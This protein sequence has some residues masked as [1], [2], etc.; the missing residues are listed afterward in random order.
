MTCKSAIAEIGLLPELPKGC[1]YGIA[2][3]LLF[4]MGHLRAASAVKRVIRKQ[5]LARKEGHLEFPCISTGTCMAVEAELGIRGHVEYL[6]SGEGL[7]HASVVN[8]PAP[9]KRS[10]LFRAGAQVA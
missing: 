10:L 3:L 4:R 2:S 7:L 8:G 6:E 1:F 9:H 5:V